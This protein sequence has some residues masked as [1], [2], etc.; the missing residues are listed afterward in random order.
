M[1]PQSGPVI[2]RAVTADSGLLSEIGAR[3]FCETF[4]ADNTPEDMAAYVASSF[5]STQIAT[6]LSDPRSTF[7]IA[8]IDTI[9][10]GYSKLHV[11]KAA[12][13]ITGEKPIELVRLYVSKGWLGRGIGTALMLACMEEARRQGYGT[14][15]LGVWEHN[16]RARAFYRK[17]EFHE[18]GQ[19]VFQ[20]GADP[21]T[22]LLME[23]SV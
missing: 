18:V 22:D 10:V 3:T 16:G 8:E 6:E 4:A 23:R 11:G 19:R 14:L 2:R 7:L 1:K 5:N 13:G 15:W 9:A 12:D 17:W 21:Q 20:L